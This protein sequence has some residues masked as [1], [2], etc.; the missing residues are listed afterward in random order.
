LEEEQKCEEMSRAGF[1]VVLMFG[2]AVQKPPYR[3]E[4]FQGRSHRDYAH[5]DAMR[6]M[7]WIDGKKLPGD[8]VFVCGAPPCPALATPLDVGQDVVHLNQIQT[9]TDLRWSHPRILSALK[10][11]Y[12]Q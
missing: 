8:T 11:L 7:A 5:H 9:V 1:R 2:S 4:F 10:S 6:G 12:G 3:S